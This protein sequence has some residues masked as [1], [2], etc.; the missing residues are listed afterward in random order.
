MGK[1]THVLTICYLLNPEG[2]GVFGI[3]NL[4][5]SYNVDQIRIES[6]I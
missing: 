5:F 4:E 2:V 6:V 1:E 3:W